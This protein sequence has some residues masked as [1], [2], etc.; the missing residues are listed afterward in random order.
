M[1]SGIYNFEY[2]KSSPFLILDAGDLFKG[3]YKK[4]LSVNAYLKIKKL[5][6]QSEIFITLGNNDFGFVKSDFEYLLSTIEK[7]NNAGI[8]VVLSLIHI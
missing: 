8:N 6:P 7:F 3:I 5:L 4:D 2:E 1:L